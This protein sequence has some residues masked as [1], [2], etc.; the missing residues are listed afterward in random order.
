MEI[1]SCWNFVLSHCCKAA[2]RFQKSMDIPAINIVGPGSYI[3]VK[4]QAIL[5][6]VKRQLCMHATA[7]QHDN[8]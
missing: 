7:R 1:I 5:G 2:A 4:P 3:S 8:A 6:L